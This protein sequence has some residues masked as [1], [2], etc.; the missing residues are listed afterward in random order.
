[1]DDELLVAASVLLVLLR[2]GLGARWSSRVGV[3][4]CRFGMGFL[5]G[6]LVLIYWLVWFGLRCVGVVWVLWFSFSA[7]FPR[8]RMT[9]S[10]I[11]AINLGLDPLEIWGQMS[12]I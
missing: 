7:G 11:L 10:E 9:G 12:V 2:L 8:A 3:C 4:C 5:V 1:M 6:L